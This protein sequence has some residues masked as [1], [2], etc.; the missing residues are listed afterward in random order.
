[1]FDNFEFNPELVPVIKLGLHAV[2]C[3]LGLVIWCLQIAVFA[4]GESTINGN[5]GW[6]FG[7]V[8]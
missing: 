5:N 4:D 3:L 7:V 1:M 6:V 8:R 2:Q